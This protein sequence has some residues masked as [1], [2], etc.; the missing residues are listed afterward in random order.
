[1][2]LPRCCSETGLFG[3][4]LQRWRWDVDDIVQ[5]QTKHIKMG[6]IAAQILFWLVKKTF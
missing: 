1:M 5:K 6:R 4:N 3:K 2:V